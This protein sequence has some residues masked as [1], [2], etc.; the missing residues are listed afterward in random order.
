MVARGQRELKPDIGSVVMIENVG[1]LVSPA[2]FDLGER[3]KVV[4]LSVSED[5]DKPLKYPRMFRAARI[6]VLNK[7]DLLPHVDFDVACAVA[8]ARLVNPNIIIV[9][10]SARGEGLDIW[11]EW[12]RRK[13]AHAR[14][15]A[16]AR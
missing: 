8:N 4:I 5:E 14:Y 12:L 15:E 9:P 6:M 16:F 11:Y 7:I 1:N 10:L 2:M 3:V 13:A